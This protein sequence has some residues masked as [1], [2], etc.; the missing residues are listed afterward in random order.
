MKTKKLTI[1]LKKYSKYEKYNTEK[2]YFNY[3]SQL[4]T[5]LVS[6]TPRDIPEVKKEKF[7]QKWATHYSWKKIKSELLQLTKKSLTKDEILK[8]L[9]N[10]IRLE[11]LTALAIIK[12]FINIPSY[13]AYFKEGF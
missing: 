4:D 12:E 8:Y 9:S 2:S 1:I 13:E 10:P 5:N 7:L 11:F 6:Y 3:L